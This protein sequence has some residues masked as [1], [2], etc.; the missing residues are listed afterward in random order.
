MLCFTAV[1]AESA[2]DAALELC[3]LSEPRL[4]VTVDLPL[5]DEG[6]VAAL[7]P[8]LA[9]GAAAVRIGSLET[10]E[11]CRKKGCI[12]SA[13]KSHNLMMGLF[14]TAPL[15]RNEDLLT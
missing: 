4:E 8:P 15:A 11:N 9:L 10:L 14:I 13:R 7:R 6:P 1:D 12:N 2:R 5:A 3:L